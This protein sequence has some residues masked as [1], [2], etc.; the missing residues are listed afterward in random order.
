MTK[1][2]TSIRI[3]AIIIALVMIAGCAKDIDNQSDSPCA[4]IPQVI[5]TSDDLDNIVGINYFG[6]MIYLAAY[7]TADPDH[8]LYTSRIYSMDADGASI[9]ELSGYT[10]DPP[11]PGIMKTKIIKDMRID[12]DGNIWIIEHVYLHMINTP[13][14]I[15]YEQEE[16][17]KYEEFDS[18]TQVCKLN[19][20]GL[21]LSSFDITALTGNG[22]V[23]YEFEIDGSGNTY[24]LVSGPGGLAVYVFDY[25]GTEKFTLNVSGFDAQLVRLNDGAVACLVPVNTVTSALPLRKIDLHTGMWGETISLPSGTHMV[26]SG[27]DTFDL[28]LSDGNR[29]H[30]LNIESDKTTE[31][32]NWADSNVRSEAVKYVKLLSDGRI[33]YGEYANNSTT[34]GE[35]IKIVLL[36]R[37][38]QT[39]TE[40]EEIIELILASYAPAPTLRK[41]VFEFN[42]TNPKYHIRLVDYMDFATDDSYYFSGLSTLTTEIIAGYIPDILD[43]SY[44]PLRQY[45][46]KGLLEDLY[47]FIDADPA[48]ERSSFLDGAL[49]AMEVNGDLYRVSPAFTINTLVG[50]PSVLGS[51]IGWNMDEFYAVI[52]ANPDA[53]VP[54]WTP[55][56]KEYFVWGIVELSLH[57][58]VD[59]STG[60]AHFDR[61]E[62]IQLLEFAGTLSNDWSA[63]EPERIISGDQIMSMIHDFGGFSGYQMYSIVFGGDLVFKGFPTDKRNGNTINPE[64][65]LAITTT[66]ANNEGAWEFISML[67]SDEWMTSNHPD[68][69]GRVP[70]NKEAFQAELDRAM[71]STMEG[72][73][74][75]Y[76]FTYEFGPLTQDG[77]DKIFA[78]ID[79]LSGTSGFDESLMNIVR[80]G[81]SDY[82]NSRVTAQE[83]A[84]IIHTRASIYVA[85][86][87]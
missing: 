34:G 21:E 7:V 65:G 45:I 47:G 51:D 69:Y 2:A 1:R 24:I 41:A 30:G 36:T 40:Q 67:L 44:L 53:S 87:S 4:F 18:Y 74:R 77:A 52:A 84:R 17:D 42:M 56:T 43:M 31:L 32:L 29:L 75:W 3:A 81:A 48:L 66:C 20:T 80:E 60:T 35:N 57:E 58:Y 38:T 15:D 37:M 50:H 33:L 10:A 8:Q 64:S 83:A 62:F 54:I 11:A 86:Q 19:N 70:L 26:Y 14:R 73:G 39:T 23:L 13:D 6:G 22:N 76:G 12:T 27:G 79:S 78:L 5:R 59:W 28:L 72:I 82:F 63:G 46:E 25:N 68:Y 9:T 55:R 71:S 61:E 85:E 16:T 49:R